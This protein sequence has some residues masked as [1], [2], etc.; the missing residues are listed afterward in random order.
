LDRE[1]GGRAKS[2][3]GRTDGSDRGE[4]K[5]EAVRQEEDPDPMWF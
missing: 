4:A 2:W 3:R 5:V 1:K